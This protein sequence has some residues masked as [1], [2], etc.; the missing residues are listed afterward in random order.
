MQ[1]TARI[2][3]FTGPRSDNT[4]PSVKSGAPQIIRMTEWIE[5]KMVN[6]PI[7]NTNC[8]ASAEEVDMARSRV[9]DFLRQQGHL[10][11]KKA[12]LYWSFDSLLVVIDFEK[13]G[14]NVYPPVSLWVKSIIR[15]LNIKIGP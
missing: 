9:I 6:F 3:R 1:E 11:A 12:E 5:W 4:E 8:R 7:D 2:L 13:N 15:G 10:F 14:D